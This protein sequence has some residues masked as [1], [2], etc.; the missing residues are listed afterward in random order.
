MK[1]L[2]NSINHRLMKKSFVVALLLFA[3]IGATFAQNARLQERIKSM[4]IAFYT[5][6]LQLTP[7]EAQ[8]FWPLFNEYEADKKKL[9]GDYK[10]PK[11]INQLSEAEADEAILASLDMEEKE[12]GLKRKY[13]TKLKTVLSAQKIAK[14]QR[15]ERAF[16]EKILEIINERRKQKRKNRKNGNN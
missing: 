6:K 12:I 14:L 16:K 3:T 5:E 8:Q 15:A 1:E 7:D 2:K 11:R 9:K 4:K 13:Y 10:L